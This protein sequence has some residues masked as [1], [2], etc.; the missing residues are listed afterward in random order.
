MRISHFHR[1]MYNSSIPATGLSE[2]PSPK[3]IEVELTESP[4]LVTS[5]SDIDVRCKRVSTPRK[6]SPQT[7][8]IE[9]LQDRTLLWEP[10]WITYST[11][12]RFYQ[13]CTHINIGWK[14]ARCT[15]LSMLHRPHANPG[16]AGRLQTM[17]CPIL[18]HWRAL[19]RSFREISPAIDHSDTHKY[20][21][22]RES[23][24]EP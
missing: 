12:S 3:T 14:L 4:N 1:V 16:N 2:D 5:D 23:D 10:N 9:P 7:P 6:V 17:C 13:L 19:Y 18:I 21:R 24:G 15:S 11:K 8:Q 22:V 20:T